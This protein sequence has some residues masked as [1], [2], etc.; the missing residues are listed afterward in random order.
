VTRRRGDVV[1]WGSGAL[2]S[3][4]MMTAIPLRIASD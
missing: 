4:A 3:G 2:G 1:C